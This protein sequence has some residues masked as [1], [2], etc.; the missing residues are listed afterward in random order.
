MNGL[1]TRLK[2]SRRPGAVT[3]WV[4]LC[5]FLILGVVA[6]GM[7]GGRMAEE[8]RRAQ[9]T[10]DAA[11]LAGGMENYKKTFLSTLKPGDAA[12]S[13]AAAN[14]YANDGVDSIVTVNIPPKSG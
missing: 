12:L 9:A 3:P 10:A 13:V 1:S 8:R 6:L 2:R 5:L 11:A 4:V 14:G 7:D